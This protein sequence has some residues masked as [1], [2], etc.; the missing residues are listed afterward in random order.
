[1]ASTGLEEISVE[2]PGLELSLVS[3]IIKKDDDYLAV[4]TKEGIGSEFL[5]VFRNT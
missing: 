3:N 4:E 1:M 5:V 2:G